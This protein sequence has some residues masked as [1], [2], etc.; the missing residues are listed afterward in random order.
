MPEEV[1]PEENGRTWKDKLNSRKFIITLLGMIATIVF[2]ALGS[3]SIKD[4]MY[5]LAWFQLGYVVAEGFA[6]GGAGGNKMM[7]FIE[8]YLPMLLNNKKPGEE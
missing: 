8:K 6:D 2:M 3:L 1:R 7:A 4:G 5:Y